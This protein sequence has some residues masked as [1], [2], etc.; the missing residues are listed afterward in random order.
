[1]TEPVVLR[2][3]FG[4]V[5][6]IL[7]WVIVVV[8]VAALVFQGKG[9]D[10]LRY[11]PL[12]LL[13]GYLCWMLFWAPAVVVEPSG[14]TLRNVLRS[15]RVTWPAIN[16]VDTKYSLTLQ[17]SAGRFTAW[18]AP[19]PSRVA[20]FRVRKADLTKLPETTYGPGGSVGLGDL[21]TSD[22]GL[23]ALHVRTQWQQLRDAGH[24][25]AGIVE[26]T[27]V[28]TT[29]HRRELLVLAVLVALGAVGS[30]V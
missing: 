5:L 27:G 7:V 4:I 10:V 16:S 14:V 21:P 20:M 12:L 23:A 15:R 11:A 6:T 8:C 30:L 24:L 25:D 3:R 13:A 26:G 19:A 29:W 9:L 17:T 22:S 1:M 18:A 28:T 2:P